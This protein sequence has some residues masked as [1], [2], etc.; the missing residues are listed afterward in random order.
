MTEYVLGFLF[1]PDLSRVVLIRKERP[2]WQAGKLNGV[3]GKVDP[4]EDAYTAMVREF[5]EETGLTEPSWI[6]YATIGGPDAAKNHTSE[7]KLTVF[8]ATSAYYDTV[9]SITDEKVGFYSVDRLM[10]D[11][12]TVTVP[13]VRWLVQMAL[14]LFRG[15][16]A[17]SF[18]IAE[19]Y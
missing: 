13:N 11:T 9:T 5:R 14:S 4:G 15:E 10:E 18:S 1:S 19:T 7:F 2:Q 16:G 8:Y 3:G 6:Q 12:G 17:K